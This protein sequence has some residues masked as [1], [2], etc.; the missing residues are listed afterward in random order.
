MFGGL[1]LMIRVPIVD[2]ELSLLDL[3][4]EYLAHDDDLLFDTAESVHEALAK[5][6]TS[7]DDV[8]VSD[9]QMPGMNGIAMLEHLRRGGDPV[10]FVLFTGRGREEVVIDALNK[11]ADFTLGREALLSTSSARLGSD[12]DQGGTRET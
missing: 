11:G 2:D 4:E 6:S 7:V 9:Y 8:I 12:D 3:A 1:R 5:I 10:P